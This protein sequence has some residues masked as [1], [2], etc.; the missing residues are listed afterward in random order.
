MKIG[1]PAETQPTDALARSAQAA[2]ASRQAGTAGGGKIERTG[3]TDKVQLS[4]ASRKLASEIGSSDTV[5]AAKVEE[6]RQAIAEGRFH[7][8]AKVVAEK[9]IAE[10]AELLE[11][12][13]RKQ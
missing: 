11:T 13:S 2:G 9:M 1:K 7:V 6:V 8:N 4:E 10:S 3:A 12:L 5:R